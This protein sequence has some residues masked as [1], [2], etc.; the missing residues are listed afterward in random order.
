MALAS[1][2]PAKSHA[3]AI[4]ELAN[5]HAF[6]DNL[7]CPWHLNPRRLKSVVI[8]LTKQQPTVA[9]K[10]LQGH[11]HSAAAAHWRDSRVRKYNPTVRVGILS[12]CIFFSFFLLLSHKPCHEQPNQTHGQPHQ[13][14]TSAQESSSFSSRP[15]SHLDSCGSSSWVLWP[16]S[17]AVQAQ[18][19][20]LT[21]LAGCWGETSQERY[22]SPARS[23]PHSQAT[24]QTVS[25]WRSRIYYLNTWS[26]SLFCCCARRG[27]QRSGYRAAAMEQVEIQC[28]VGDTSA[29]WMLGSTLVAVNAGQPG[30]GTLQGNFSSTTDSPTLFLLTWTPL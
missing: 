16:Q 11:K 9:E 8:T 6:P 3:S 23:F 24:V 14:W 13:I 10:R 2:G 17:G 12:F 4:G 28:V 7:W 19:W 26:L 20:P 25:Q 5:Q 22:K 29:G 30:G 27:G 15:S 18:W 1:W 21:Y